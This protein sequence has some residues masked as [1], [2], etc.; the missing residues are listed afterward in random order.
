MIAKAKKISEKKY[1][2]RTSVLVYTSPG[3]VG[4][5]EDP[6]GYVV[7]AL[8]NRP[9]YKVIVTYEAKTGLALN[10][11]IVLC[12]LDPPT[13]GSS[14]TREKFLRDLTK[15]LRLTDTPLYINPTE[16]DEIGLNGDLR[17]VA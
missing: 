4:S 7:E 17:E 5:N 6:T 3:L 11:D 14:R 9:D 16:L 12:R 13:D 15:K 10:F 2:K 1:D 8:R